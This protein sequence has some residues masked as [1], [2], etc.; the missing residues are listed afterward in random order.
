MDKDKLRQFGIGMLHKGYS[1][2]QVKKFIMQRVALGNR[3]TIQPI[4]QPTSQSTSQGGN[5]MGLIKKY[6]PQEEWQRA[7]NVMMGESG[8]RSDA[9]GDDYP[10]NGVYAPSYGLFQIR[11][12]PGRP[13]KE[14]L[15]DPE[16][17]TKY[18]ADMW[19][20]QGWKPWHNTA[21]KL[22]YL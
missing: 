7:Y 20:G 16:F 1:V 11:G 13:K 18:A 17:N 9:V 2:D 22:G 21:R 5:Q 10:I 3:A 12:L 14:Q 19:R 4:S 6:F 8:G 15:F